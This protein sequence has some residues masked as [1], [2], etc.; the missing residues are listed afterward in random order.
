MPK[1]YYDYLSEK[2]WT[3][4]W[5]DCPGDLLYH[6]HMDV[7]RCYVNGQASVLELGWGILSS[8]LTGMIFYAFSTKRLR[9]TWFPVILHS[10]HGVFML[11]LILGLVLGLA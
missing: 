8:V 10:G 5:R 4:L 7:L 3:R 6:V 1:K 2:E 9:S 11:F